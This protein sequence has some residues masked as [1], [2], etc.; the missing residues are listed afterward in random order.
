MS[1][2]YLKQSFVKMQNADIWSLQ[3]LKVNGDGDAVTYYSRQV[4]LSPEGKI[5]S[6]ADDL[7]RKYLSAKGIDSFSGVDEYTGDVVGD[8]I[9]KFKGDNLLINTE[10]TSL[11]AV[12][13][14]PDAEGPI[15]A[16]KFQ[17]YVL[18]TTIRDDN[19]MVPVKLI[20]MQS[21][22]STLSN[23][24]ILGTERRN[25]HEITE[26][27]LTLKRSIDVII[28]GR[29]VYMLTLAG[30]NLFAME[31]AYKAV[32]Q[33]KVSDVID[34]GFVTNPDLFKTI[35]TS[36]Q[37]PRRFI[38]YNQ[39]RL[40]TLKNTNRRKKLAQKFGMKLEGNTIDT[41]DEKTSERLVKFLC[42]KA[43]LDPLDESPVE[44][45]AAK[46]WQ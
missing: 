19:E 40:D 42:N 13:A 1:K 23:R 8:V 45:S 26:P 31:R 29:T 34:C 27:V 12:L 37:N 2:E 35:A 16:K 28:L 10:M 21:P 33:T 46:S 22:V 11:F 39:T 20:S 36:G 17:A 24:F 15:E 43:M 7:V 25:F 5:K 41:N 9:Y 38:S 18:Q 4:C 44:V 30:E 14:N 32:C 3:L 6:I